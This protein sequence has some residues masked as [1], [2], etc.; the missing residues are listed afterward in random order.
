M[1][2][3]E[4]CTSVF[5]LTTP[6]DEKRHKDINSQLSLLHLEVV[7]PS[8]TCRGQHMFRRGTLLRH[9]DRSHNSLKWK[10]AHACNAN[11][12]LEFATTE[13]FRLTDNEI[14]LKQLASCSA[15]YRNTGSVE[16]RHIRRLTR[17]GHPLVP[18]V[19]FG[20]SLRRRAPN[21]NNW[22]RAEMC[23]LQL[24]SIACLL[25]RSVDLQAT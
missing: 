16:E 14:I 2:S 3:R 19:K 6:N 23:G 20:Y 1:R 12:N 9:L 22:M 13:T 11:I 25:P 7:S 18:V 21:D 15:C 17:R 10:T 5:L 8:A 24:R 4:V